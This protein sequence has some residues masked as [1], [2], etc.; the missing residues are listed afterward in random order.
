MALE[1]YTLYRLGSWLTAR[2]PRWLVYAVAAL[3][4]ELNCAFSVRSR[5]GVY[6]NLSHVL[7]PE[8]PARRRWQIVR[9]VFRNFAYSV[10]DFFRIPQMNTANL[11]RFV[12]HVV[13]WEHLQA[14]MDSRVGGVL[15]TVHMG[16]WELGAAYLGLRGVPLTAVALPHRD[17]RINRI[18]M[19]SREASGIEVVPIGGAMRKLGEALTRGRFIALWSD[20]DVSGRGIALPFF[21][22]AARMPI[23]HALLALQTGAMIVPACIYRLPNGQT[24]FDI[25][26]PI[27]PNPATDTIESL[28]LDCLVTLEEFIRARPEQWSSFYDLWNETALP[29]A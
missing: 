22:Q 21:G 1:N 28:T 3:L 10:V 18:F 15:I 7:P 26:P 20:R 11:D 14:A 4:A 17:P 25:R 13:G 12:T 6:A 2:L 16:S 27:I 5:R 9:Q 29:V 24:A 19:D 23:G 8:M